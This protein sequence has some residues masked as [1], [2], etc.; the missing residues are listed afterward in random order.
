MERAVLRKTWADLRGHRLQ[1][2]LIILTI[3]AATATLTVA[4]V[5][6]AGAED[7]FE[8]AFNA[9]NGSHVNAVSFPV[10]PGDPVA[11]LSTVATM[12]EVSEMSGPF[13][14]L[15]D[16]ALLHDGLKEEMDLAALG[17][18]PPAVGRPVLTSGAWLSGGNAPQILLTRDFARKFGIEAGDTIEVVATDG[19]PVS[20][21]VAGLTVDISRG[22]YPDWR[23]TGYVSEATLALIA[24]DRSTW[25]SGVTIRLKDPQAVGPFLD[26]LHQRFPTYA[27]GTDNWLDVKDDFVIWPKVF[28][29]LLGLFAAFALVAVGMI[30]ANVISARVLAQYR[31]IG[32]MKAV[33]FTP[34]QVVRVFLYQHLALG[35]AGALLGIAL[36]TALAPLMLNRTAEALNTTAATPFNPLLAAGILL[37]SLAVVAFFTWLPARGA[38]RSQPSRRSP[39]GQGRSCRGHRYRR[40]W[41]CDCGCIRWSRWASRM[42]SPV[43]AGPRRPSSRSC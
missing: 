20:V 30:V 17:T 32:M 14:V 24:P 23:P 27:I 18:E 10:H 43:R 5:T 7:P 8:R 1:A 26:A 29:I 35:L 4:L 3:A 39:P 11:D 40:G 42:R 6:Q 16:A 15:Y 21:T 34:A 2:F 13:P 36:G 9:S 41:P 31:D 38:G 33:G 19:T 22:P 28:S 37:G 12:P 25:A